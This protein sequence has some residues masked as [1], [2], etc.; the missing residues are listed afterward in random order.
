MGHFGMAEIAV[1]VVL[2]M[3]LF[4]YK[5]LPDIGKSLGRGIKQFR[6]SLTEPDEIDVTPSK[7]TE[8]E[9]GKKS[10]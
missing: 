6:R 9:N 5:R 8:S 3:A 7:A 2:A 4:G 1:I 10:A